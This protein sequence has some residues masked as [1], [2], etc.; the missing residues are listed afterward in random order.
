MLCEVYDFEVI[1]LQLTPLH[2]LF[3]YGT[4]LSFPTLEKLFFDIPESSILES[5]RKLPWWV[6]SI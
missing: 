5:K 4:K 6:A 1:L 2:Y 3:T